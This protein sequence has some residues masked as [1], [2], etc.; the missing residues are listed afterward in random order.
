MIN[1]NVVENLGGTGISGVAFTCFD[2]YVP[3]V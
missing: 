3:G 2:V 1:L